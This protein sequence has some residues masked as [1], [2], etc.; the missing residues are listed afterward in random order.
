ML[1]TSTWTH[2]ELLWWL[3]MLTLAGMLTISMLS[4]SLFG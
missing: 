3:V 4:G 2:T 1:P